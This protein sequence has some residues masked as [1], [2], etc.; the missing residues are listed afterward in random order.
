MTMQSSNVTVLPMLQTAHTLYTLFCMP[1]AKAEKVDRK[2]SEA[3][4][5]RMINVYKP[6]E[7]LTNRLFS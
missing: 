2:L 3:R 4:M 5:H 7:T 1:S 6:F